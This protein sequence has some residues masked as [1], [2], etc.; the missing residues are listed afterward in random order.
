MTTRLRTRNWIRWAEA[1]AT[2]A[3]KS[4][5]QGAVTLIGTDVAGVLEV[6]W[7][8]VGSGAALMAVLSLLT[9]LAGLPEAPD[10]DH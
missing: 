9:S 2:R 10:P 7:V 1:A 3:V 5:A 4:A 8:G 6:D